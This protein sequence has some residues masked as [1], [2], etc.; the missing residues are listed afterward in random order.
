MPEIKKFSESVVTLTNRNTLTITNEKKMLAVSET[1]IALIA[2][3]NPLTVVGSGLAVQKLDVENGNLKVVGTVD[4]L[5]YNQN[6]EHLFKRI[7]K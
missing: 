3:Q 1:Q 7:F 2:C 6:K 5:K 4:G